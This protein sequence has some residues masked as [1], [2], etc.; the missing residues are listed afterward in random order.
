MAAA[1]LFVISKLCI[2]LL[3]FTGILLLIWGAGTAYLLLLTFSAAFYRSIT[4]DKQVKNRYFCVLIPAHDEEMVIQAA[5]DQFANI[6]YPSSLYKVVVIADNCTD[7]TVEIVR[8]SR[9][10]ILE[11]TNNIQ[12]GKGFALAWAI[13]KLIRDD[14]VIDAFIIMD[15]DSVLSP[16]FLQ[17]MNSLLEEGYDAMQA[18]YTVM[19]SDENWRTRLMT[20]AL[21]LAHH[22]KPLG[23]R[24]LGLS[25]G[26]KGNG[27]CFSCKVLRQV[28]WSG[29]SITED[30]DY[31]LRLAESKIRVIYCPEASVKAQMPVTASQ[32]KTQRERWESGRYG[33]VSRSISLI[34][35]AL[36]EKNLLLLDRSLDLLIPPFAEFLALPL[37]MLFFTFL[38]GKALGF[39]V[40]IHAL[41]IGWITVLAA[42]LLYLAL[43]LFLAKTPWK[44]VAS[45]LFAPIY[46]LWKFFLYGGLILHKNTGEW[47][48]TERRSMDQ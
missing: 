22:V 3:C 6:Y 34:K 2:A 20:C 23:R 43:G 1:V 39:I 12:K 16:N 46:I 4:A 14:N 19:N 28:P 44:A 36:K 42:Q 24:V 31:A 9:F 33:L 11:R 27:M 38:S 48:R 32:A 41:M 35:K 25:D 40:I 18:R 45:L 8:S 17:V 13:E 30:I 29:E 15:A 37:L 5:L 47:K 7:R 26:L 21:D 10:T